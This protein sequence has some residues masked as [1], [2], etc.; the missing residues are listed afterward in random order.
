MRR[1]DC[2]L[3]LISIAS[4]LCLSDSISTVLASANNIDSSII[5]EKT[6]RASDPQPNFP[7]K[8]KAEVPDDIAKGPISP[9]EGKKI[10]EVS[11]VL[12]DA[13]FA[14]VGERVRELL[15]EKD[16]LEKGKSVSEGFRNISEAIKNT[17]EIIAII[18][19]AGWTY[20][21]F[22]KQRQKYPRANLAHRITHRSLGNGKLL[23]NIDATLSNAG[24]VLIRIVSGELRIQHV[25][26]LSSIVAS[27]TADAANSFP[28]LSREFSRD[29]TSHPLE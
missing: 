4:L 5:P 12:S 9:L 29:A 6:K 27:E 3:H 26:P 21:L 15:K 18:V 10:P 16:N 8:P 2:L 7:G 24:A 28:K 1:V 25:L 20:V 19:G 17:L 23:M 11:I 22:I 13:E 14:R